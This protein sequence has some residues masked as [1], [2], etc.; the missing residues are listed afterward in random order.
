MI[1][2]FWVAVVGVLGVG[3]VAFAARPEATQE[4]GRPGRPEGGQM[5]RAAG[6]TDAQ[7]AQLRKIRQEDQKQAIRRRADMRIAHMELNELLDAP[8]IDEKAVALKVKALSDLQAA[9]LKA[10]VDQRL[11]MRKIASADQLEKLRSMHRERGR[12]G[13]GER[14]PGRGPRPPGRFGGPDGQRGPDGAGPPGDDPQDD[15]VDDAVR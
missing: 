10:R 1:R 6:L 7:I 15:D 12:G 3:A 5:E 13:E 8:T 9:A 11:A 2:S 14:G 4:G